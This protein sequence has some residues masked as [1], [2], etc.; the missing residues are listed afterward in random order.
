M[1]YFDQEC[2]NILN[3]KACSAKIF[4]KLNINAEAI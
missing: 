4:K 3:A 2:D 1:D